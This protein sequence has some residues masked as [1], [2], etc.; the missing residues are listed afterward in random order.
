MRL[1]SLTLRGFMTSFAG[2]EVSID[3][4]KLPDGLIAF[5]GD[6]GAGKTTLLEAAP[7]GVYR[8]MLSRQRGIE[9]YAM[10]R[11]SA[12]ESRWSIGGVGYRQRLSVDGIKGGSSAV[13]TCD[14]A[15]RP[16][17]DGKVST[18]D[19]A[20]AAVFPP[21]HVFKASAFATQNK[22][23]SFVKASKK[24]RRDIFASFL[25]LDRL[26]RM[27][28][29]ANG[30][31]KQI[32]QVRV[33]VL[34]DLDSLERETTTA[35]LEQLQQ[36]LAAAA[37]A[38]EDATTERD[39]LAGKIAE[40]EQQL[41]IL[42]DQ[43]AA[44]AAA[45][46]RVAAA[47]DA[48]ERIR[49]E[50][51]AFEG[52]ETVVLLNEAA[53]VANLTASHHDRRQELDRL[54]A[55]AVASETRELDT[56]SHDSLEKLADIDRKLAGNQQ[57][58]AMADDIRTAVAAIEAA[59]VALCFDRKALENA[60]HAQSIADQTLRSVEGQ[61][62]DLVP[63]E[64]DVARARTDAELLE[65]VP[66]GGVGDY[67]ACQFLT[68]V[69]QAKA[70]LEALVAKLQPKAE[71]ADRIARLT[72]EAAKRAEGIAALRASIEKHEATR[73][74]HAKTAGYA[75]KLAASSARVKELHTQRTDT[76]TE[77][78]QRLTQARERHTAAA[79]ARQQAAA[80]FER[81][82]TAEM[83]ATVARIAKRLEHAE[84]TR[85]RLQVG[86]GE[87][88]QRHLDAEA[89]LQAVTA[90]HD[91][92]AVLRG[93]LDVFRSERDIRI[94]VIAHE[95]S[96]A[97]ALSLRIDEWNVRATRARDLRAKLSRLETEL[98]E[99]R[100][101]EKALGR[102]GLPDLEIDQAGP[103]ISARTNE[104]LSDCFGA[105]FS[106]ELVTQ[107]ARADGQG[108]K[109]EF[110]VLVTDNTSG[111]QRDIAD[112]SGGEEVIVAEAL[113]NAI[114]I[115]VNERSQTPMRTCFR[116]ETTGA[117]T[118]EN[119]QRYI[120][121]LRKVRE[122]G[123]FDQ[124]LFISHDPDAYAL[125]D[126]HIRVADGTATVVLPPYQEAA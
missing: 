58:Q 4:S 98:L 56:I 66:C 94:A 35:M 5:V 89:A 61:L 29:A 13:L 86:V 53:E 18:Y 106:I 110:T 45:S 16:L 30:A 37:V 96:R 19:P 51:D 84:A 101:L 112:L 60:R 36:Q 43:V 40:A 42:S 109:D 76:I 62:A 20:I 8:E 24:E 11:D 64:R 87:A 114:A 2:R 70:G 118:K 75:E 99:W 80:G 117:L 105:R 49:Q 91:E 122:L 111:D 54:T 28:E 57:I 115:Y 34:A 9:N 103:G 79:A 65:R 52:A 126:A 125:A 68:N 116:D 1:E 55:G 14:R 123:G 38:G 102:G 21:L 3:F 26:I 50:F 82:S 95:A 78:E 15:P 7:A 6:N 27:S 92:A 93:S 85:R 32:D 44:H 12:I 121:M 67:A 100:L 71:F 74:A 63:I 22:S 104:I 69:Q 108:M 83:D 120:Q 73:T 47:A 88:T 10:D 77:T 124:I 41:A 25:T 39:R 17:N 90:G 23:G 46:D 81:A 97:A 119:T 33:R 113:M 48:L 72:R 59:D 31:A 107:V